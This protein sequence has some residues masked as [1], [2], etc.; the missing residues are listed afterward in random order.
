MK[1]YTATQ[2]RKMPT[3]SQG[4][5]DNLK[6]DDGKIRVWLSRCGIADGAE[7]DDQVTVEKLR[8]GIWT[9]IDQYPGGED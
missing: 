4:Q 2:L 5:F 6:S 1:R 8:A 7:Y 9:Q 3:I